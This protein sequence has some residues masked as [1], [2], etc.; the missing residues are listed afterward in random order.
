MVSVWQVSIFSHGKNVEGENQLWKT[1]K[2]IYISKIIRKMNN[3]QHFIHFI[4][5]KTMRKVAK[6]RV[7]T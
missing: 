5:C 3:I 4:H 1:R 6:R 7:Q 2:T